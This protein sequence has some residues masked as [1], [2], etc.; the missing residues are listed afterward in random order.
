MEKDFLNSQDAASY[1]D[2]SLDQL[3]KLNADGKIP[4]YRPSGGKIYYLKSDLFEWVLKG[5]RATVKDINSHV[6][7][8]LNTKN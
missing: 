4:T 3:Y 5:R 8:S 2:I 6:I 7:K 1:L